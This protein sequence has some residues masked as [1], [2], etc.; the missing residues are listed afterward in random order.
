MDKK[1]LD[2]VVDQIVSETR[3]DYN[4]QEGD[5]EGRI[6]TPFQ[7]PFFFKKSLYILGRFHKIIKVSYFTSCIYKITQFIIDT[8]TIQNCFYDDTIFSFEL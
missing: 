5:D 7:K 4:T 8:D 6:Y 1:F 2:K 3:I